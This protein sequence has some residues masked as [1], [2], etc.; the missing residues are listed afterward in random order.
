MSAIG[1][2]HF[3]LWVMFATG[4]S[5]QSAWLAALQTERCT[6]CDGKLV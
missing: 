5:R 2:A 4:N 3:V 1:T 6:Y